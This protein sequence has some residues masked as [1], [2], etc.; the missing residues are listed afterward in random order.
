MFAPTTGFNELFHFG[1]GVSAATSSWAILLDA[2][3]IVSPVQPVSLIWAHSLFNLLHLCQ[4]S[5]TSPLHQ[6]SA[7]QMAFSIV[8]A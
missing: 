2:M 3:L 5:Y 6:L 8:L 4:V 1:I 7:E